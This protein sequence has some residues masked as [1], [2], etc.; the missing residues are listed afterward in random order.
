MSAVQAL[1]IAALFGVAVLHVKSRI[2]GALAT[3]GWCVAAA[4]F[5]G[6]ELAQREGGVIF[7]GITTP[8]WLFF[9]VISGVFLYNIG[10]VVRALA[11]RARLKSARQSGPPAQ[12]P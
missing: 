12:G 3:A 1:M 5:G 4:I 2:G 7:L 9:V 8:K 11:R 6:W 10:I